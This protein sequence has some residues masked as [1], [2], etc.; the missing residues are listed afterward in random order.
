MSYSHSPFC[1]GVQEEELVFLDDNKNV[2][3]GST[4]CRREENTPA[5]PRV[6]TRSQDSPGKNTRLQGLSSLER[7]L[8]QSTQRKLI[9]KRGK[10]ALGCGQKGRPLTQSKE[11]LAAEQAAKVREALNSKISEKAEGATRLTISQLAEIIRLHN[12]SDPKNQKTTKQLALRWSMTSL[13]CSR[14]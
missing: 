10:V 8:E 5:S 4:S 9:C 12:T 11:S 3:S 13:I 7:T 1:S 6:N 2:A 14:G